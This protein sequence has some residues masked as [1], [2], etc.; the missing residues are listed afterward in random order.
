L[1]IIALKKGKKPQTAQP[2]T[3]SPKN[4]FEDDT[5]DKDKEINNENDNLMLVN[6]HDEKIK[7]KMEGAKL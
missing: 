1:K 6:I 5:G 7:P 3:G 4:D 2:N